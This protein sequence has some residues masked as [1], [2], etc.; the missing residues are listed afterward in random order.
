[1]NYTNQT[2]VLVPSFDSRLYMLCFL[3][4]IILLVFTPNLKYL[5]PLSLVANLVMTASLVLIYFYSLMVNT[6]FFSPLSLICW[7]RDNW[8]EQFVYLHIT[9][10]CKVIYDHKQCWRSVPTSPL[11][12]NNRGEGAFLVFDNLLKK[13][14]LK[15]ETVAECLVVSSCVPTVKHKVKKQLMIQKWPFV[16]WGSWNSPFR[17]KSCCSTLCFSAGA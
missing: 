4:A 9:P 5:A 8:K 3:P 1:M 16:S 7:S 11:A 14:I 2:Q 12:E 13:V 15:D 6:W 17:I 10:S